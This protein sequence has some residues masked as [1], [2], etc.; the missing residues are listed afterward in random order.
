MIFVAVALL[1]VAAVILMQESNEVPVVAPPLE[2]EEPQQAAAADELPKIPFRDIA[3]EAGIDFVHRGG[4]TGEKM[5]PESGGS[6][7]AFFD[8]DNDGDA[9]LLLVSGCAWP[10]NEPQ[11]REPSNALALY[12]NDDGKFTNVTDDVGLATDVYGQGLAIGDYDADGDDDVFL[13]AVGGNRMFRNDAGQF[14]DVTEDS[15]VAGSADDWTTSTGFFDYDR[16][17]DLDLFVCNYLRW[18]REIDQAA[19]TRVPGQGLTYAHPANFD[20]V[21]NYL[22]RNE[23]GRFAD[24]AAEAGI[25]ITDPESGKPL[26]KA[27]AV[28]FVDFDHDGWMDI[29]VANDTVRH[30]LFRNEHDGTFEEVGESRGFALNAAGLTT[31]GMGIDAAWFRNNDDLA[32]ALSNF[33]DEMTSFYVL[34]GRRRD[35]FFTDETISLGIGGPT[36]N[37]LTFGLLFDDFDLDGRV[38]LVEA[39]GHLE[40]TITVAQPSQSYKQPAKVFWNAGASAQPQFADLPAANVG[41][42]SKPIVGRGLASADIDGDGDLDLAIT[43]VEGPPLLLRNEQQLGN[44]W[45]RCKLAGPPGNPH[46]IGATL[47]LSTGGITQRRYVHP[48]RSYLSQT[49]PIVTF[50]LGKSDAAEKLSVT[51]P[52]GSKQDVKVDAVDQTITVAQQAGQQVAQQDAQQVAPQP[53][54]DFPSLANTAKAQLENGEFQKAIELLKRALEL[55]PE[56][57]ATRRNLARAY[58][59]SGQPELAIAELR[60]LQAETAETS[61]AVAYLSGLAA[62]RQLRYDEAIEHLQKSVELDPNEA[63]LRFQLGIALSSLGRSDEAREQF[64]KAA[65]LDPLHGGAQY[66]LATIA[67]KAG[68]Q[69]AAARLMRDYQ[70]IRTIKGPASPQALEECRYTKPEG[71][72][73]EGAPIASAGPT[74]KFV[75]ADAN[76]S[77]ASQPSGL[78]DV[79]VLALE[80]NGRYQLV[81]VADD[82]HVLVMN[83]D[84]AGRVSISAKSEQPIAAEISRATILPANAFV[85]ERGRPS[86]PDDVQSATGDQPEIAIVTPE[87][88]WLMRYGPASG[89]EDLTESSGLSSAAG[90]VARWVDLDHDGDIDVCTA[91]TSGLR[92]WRNNSDGTFVEATNEFRLADVGPCSDFAAADLDGI[93][94]GVDLIVTGPEGTS[95]WLNQYAGTFAKEPTVAWPSAAHILCDDFNNDGLPDVVLLAPNELSLMTTGTVEQHK[96]SLD[97]QE[98]DAA[99]TID[100]DNDGWLDIAISGRA[101]NERKAFVVRN[102]GGQFQE[103]AEPIPAPEMRAGTRLLDADIDGDDHTDLVAIGQ[104]GRLVV[105]R[106]ETPTANRQLK[107]ALRSF[108]GSPS[109]IGVRVQVRAGNFVVTRWTNRELPIEIGIDAKSKLDSIQTLW[110]NG[111]AKNEIDVAVV[112]EPLRITIVEFVRSSSCPFLYAWADG[113]WQFV[114]DLLGTAP[115]NV[116]VARGVPMPPDPDE[117]VVLGPAERFADGPVAARLRITSELREVIYLDQAQL[118]AVDHPAESTVFSRDRAA[119]SAVAGPQIAVGRNLRAPRSAI[120]SDGIDRTEMLAKEDGVF[121]PPGRVLPPP[122]VGFTEPLLIE[123]DFGKLESSDSLLLAATGWFKFGNS[124]T[125]IAAS[126]RTNLQAIW[127]RLEARDAAGHWHVVDEMVGFPAG[128]T[129]TIVCDLSGKLPPG[130]ERLRLTTSFEVRWDRIALYEA[131]PADT[132]QITELTPT[133]AELQWHGFAALRPQSPDRPQVPNLDQLSNTPPWLTNVEGWCTRYGD[134]TPLVV[135]SDSM[136]AILN[137]GDGATIEFDAAALP[138]RSPST[139]RTLL[140]FTRG[141]IKE[142]D[143]NS[144]ADRRVDPLP[145][146]QDSETQSDADWQLEYNTRWVPRHVGKAFQPDEIP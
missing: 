18:T 73:L 40:E 15:G 58:V 4:A 76:P 70:R 23:G 80:D 77:D 94:L 55:Q 14:I 92:V 39:N 96:R 88:T 5:L 17:G 112:R 27:L 47:E 52:D 120:G 82:G 127:P 144:L 140:L 50:G 6:G 48:T 101:D 117:V 61:P 11:P 62:L 110:M 119:P 93:N 60:K 13:T 141:W 43:Q 3:S 103:A 16:D 123:L 71:P 109:S 64:E 51:W 54:A 113:G 106:N 53:D 46:A 59:L 105:L 68:D 72:E 146:A 2:R 19:T 99:T 36:R 129:K 65:E 22:Y 9:D 44:H 126:Q 56:S 118:L 79:A 78:L 35:L 132:A 86:D 75:L 143:P 111:I 115:L 122:T 139:A 142:A 1:I 69:E 12:R 20:G 124:S 41:D 45:L 84:D 21:Q 138:A 95:L 108:V 31:S 66:Q 67:R 37:M 100:I 107:L 87:R 131:M 116:A 49:E 104:E 28:T 85:D 98:L 25:H 134:I 90:D 33:A 32:I 136:V 81:G 97:L 34:E 125:N 121:A 130:V 145:G 133:D 38:D 91:S 137:S 63:A 89:F 114:T 29:F 102:S 24:V 26:G 74:S 30:F 10:W 135:E 83:Y 8:Y 7:C 128:N 42:L 57:A